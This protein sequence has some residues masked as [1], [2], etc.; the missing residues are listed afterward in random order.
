MQKSK[1]FWAIPL[2][3]QIYTSLG[4]EC[5]MENP[6]SWTKATLL[7]FETI[8]RYEQRVGLKPGGPSLA[9]VIESELNL[10]GYLTPESQE[11]RRRKLGN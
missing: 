6:A 4:I 3:R 5:D 11:P 8:Q 2:M 10:A 9:S 1:K 7:I